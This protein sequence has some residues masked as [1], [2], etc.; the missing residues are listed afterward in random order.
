MPRATVTAWRVGLAAGHL[1]QAGRLV[2]LPAGRL[3]RVRAGTLALPRP[4]VKSPGAQPAKREGVLSEWYG[5][6]A[7]A[8]V[9]TPHS[10]FCLLPPIANPDLSAHC[11][12]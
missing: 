4:M 3:M 11:A 7:S 8:F 6:R 9:S 12:L 5:A 1:G 2:R 10:P